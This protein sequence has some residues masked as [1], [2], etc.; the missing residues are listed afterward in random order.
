[1]E[2]TMLIS[3]GPL[4][5]TKRERARTRG[6]WRTTGG[7]PIQLTICNWPRPRVFDEDLISA[8]ALRVFG[9]IDEQDCW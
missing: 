2:I 4:C 7:P 1:M 6:Y 8:A 3:T 9:T 5:R